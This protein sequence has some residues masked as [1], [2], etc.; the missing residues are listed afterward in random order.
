MNKKIY[1][2]I[3]HLFNWK[4]RLTGIPRTIDEIVI[5]LKDLDNVV[6]V[7]W[8]RGTR[9][10][11]SV[12]IDY[13]YSDLAPRDRSFFESGAHKDKG[14]SMPAP[15]RMLRRVLYEVPVLARSAT[16]TKRAL[17]KTKRTV[18]GFK[19]TNEHISI[20]KGDLLFIPNGQWDDSA[21][22][23]AVLAYKRQQG[24]KLAFICY[25]ILPIVVPQY[26]GQWREPLENFTRRV[27]SACDVVFCISKCTQ[28]DLENW[29]RVNKLRL[30][31]TKVI[32]LGDSFSNDRP[33][34]PSSKRFV[35]S[36]LSTGAEDFILSVGT[37]EARKNHT[38]LYY[39][40]KLAKNR[41]IK[42]PRL[43]IAGRPG[44]RTHDI[45]RI[46]EDDPDVNKQ[47]IILK[48]TGDEELSWLY[49]NCKFTI[50]PSFYEG[51][52]LPIAESVA[53]GVPCICSNTS[54][55]VEVA[56]DIPTYFDPA[57]PD[58]LLDAIISMNDSKTYLAAKKRTE[59][60]L[61]VSWDETFI[62][63]INNPVFGRVK[64]AK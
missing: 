50:Y 12:N 31:K 63:I 44:Y 57:S 40:Y 48:D 55:M 10:F 28:K 53:K 20:D 16:F 23:E 52:G 22:I 47:I 38:L 45:I 24:A 4:G 37:I 30:P 3:T 25:D 39:T 61:P 64:N 56:S 13:Y 43:V 36:G 17:R 19:R 5:R 9:Q 59:K 46:M 49:A 7:T 26:S 15:E 14:P 34:V 33:K 51:W 54:S 35:N 2:D 8:D 60:Y 21:Y 32:R 29:L 18:V 1:F 41:N 6:F 27:T 42:L 58:E 62:Q 11:V